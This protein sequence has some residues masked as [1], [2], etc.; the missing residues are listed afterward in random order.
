MK[1]ITRIVQLL[2]AIIPDQRGRTIKDQTLTYKVSQDHQNMPVDMH[3]LL[4]WK[5]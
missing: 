1:L 3:I 5:I 2:L 4:S